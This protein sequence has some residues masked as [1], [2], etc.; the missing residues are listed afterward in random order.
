MKFGKTYVT[1][2]DL[3]MLNL[4]KV[5]QALKIYNSK[6]NKKKNPTQFKRLNSFVPNSFMLGFCFLVFEIGAWEVRFLPDNGIAE[7]GFVSLWG[8]LMVQTFLTVEVVIWSSFTL[9]WQKTELHK[10]VS[11]F[12]FGLPMLIFYSWFLGE[13]R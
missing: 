3:W 1:D 10:I 9:Q 4:I 11:C 2:F 6:E 13:T 7:A 5:P 8:G 12:F